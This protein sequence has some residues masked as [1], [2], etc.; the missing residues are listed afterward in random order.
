MCDAQ[1]APS[2]K[3]ANCSSQTEKDI[4]QSCWFA[5][6]SEIHDSVFSGADD[7][8]SKGYLASFSFLLRAAHGQ[9]QSGSWQG[10]GAGTFSISASTERCLNRD[11]ELLRDSKC[12]VEMSVYTNVLCFHHYRS[13]PR[14]LLQSHLTR[15]WLPCEPFFRWRQRPDV[16][17]VLSGVKWFL[18]RCS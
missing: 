14:C 11:G 17:G 12:H 9:N 2:P 15:E 10:S 8:K 6:G 3:K 18:D 1:T 7:E 13:I 4:S 5:G 16:S